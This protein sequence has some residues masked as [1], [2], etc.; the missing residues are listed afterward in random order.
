MASSGPNKNGSNFFITLTDQHLS[1]LDKKHT[2]FGH[3]VEDESFLVLDK[4]NQVFVNDQDN[5]RPMQNIRIRHTMVIDD[6]F[7][8]K[9]TEFGFH[10]AC[11]S[12]SPSPVELTSKTL[13]DF[14]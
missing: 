13:K 14:A 10:L 6:P 1:N 11:P 7:E 5:F 9:E 12:R 4:I 8:G 2:I 3:V